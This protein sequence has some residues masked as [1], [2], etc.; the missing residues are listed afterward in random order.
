MASNHTSNYNLNQWKGADKVLREEFNADNQKIDTALKG[1]SEQI[2]GKAEQDSLNNLT[3]VVSQKAQ[4]S[5]LDAE[6]AARTKGDEVLEEQLS[7]LQP[8]AGLQKIGTVEIE[9]SGESVSLDLRMI[10]WKQWKAV[11][12]SLDAYISY[13]GNVSVILDHFTVGHF[14]GNQSMPDDS[15][16]RELG[17]M[18]FYPLFDDRHT[19]CAFIMGNGNASFG[20]T[21]NRYVNFRSLTLEGLGGQ[22]LAG[23]KCEIFGEK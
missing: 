22:I 14:S 9:T 18:L 16:N 23:T 2:K 6:I 1:L 7:E 5:D 15:P 21:S 4:Q 13:S 12:L 3:Q 20:Y 17:H 19:V 10:D 8:K 11:H